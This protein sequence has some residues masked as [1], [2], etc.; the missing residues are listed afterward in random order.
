[1]LFQ[2]LASFLTGNKT[3]GESPE[4]QKS[5]LEQ[6]P[7]VVVVLWAV[8]SIAVVLPVRANMIRMV[9]TLVADYYKETGL[10]QFSQNSLSNAA[11]GFMDLRCVV[12]SFKQSE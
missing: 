12:R 9:G 10:H 8:S 4:T 5:Y 1:M 3:F 11:P 2:A 6:L 7:V